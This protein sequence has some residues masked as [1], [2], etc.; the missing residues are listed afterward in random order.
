M[1]WLNEGDSILV[2][3]SST[4][5]YEIKKVGGVVSCSC[6]AWKVLGG[7]AY[8]RL[9]KHILK[10]VYP[11]C[12]ITQQNRISKDDPVLPWNGVPSIFKL[13]KNLNQL[14]TVID[15]NFD[16]EDTDEESKEKELTK[17]VP[18]VLL[19]HNWEP[20]IDPTGYWISEKFDGCRAWW[21]GQ[22]FISRLGN[23]FHAPEWFKNKFPK[24]I[25]LDGELWAGRGKFQETM[26][27]V[28]KLIPNDQEWANIQYVVFD[29]PKNKAKFEKRVSDLYLI[30]NITMVNQ[31][32]CS[33]IDHLKE[34]LKKVEEKGGEGLMLR[35]AGSYYE[36]GRS[37]TLLKVKTWYDAEATVIAHIP[38]KGKHKGRLGALLVKMPNDK[39]FELGTGFSDKERENPPNIGT[40][41][42]YRYVK[43][44][45]DGIPNPASY[46]RIAENQ[47]RKMKK[48][49]LDPDVFK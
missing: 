28:K 15:N 16:E 35:Q 7:P 34:E 40:V 11:D 39:E 8:S 20:S 43:L 36:E 17:P 41:I 1:K 31:N 2:K 14:K 19:A 5:P 45:K 23:I 4:K 22:N 48:N 12:M 9:C 49:I 29:M 13:N 46:W 21:D 30:P 26:S 6:I 24:D 27:I 42:T 44:T 10:N 32:I 18:P 25:I 3:G 47:P 38:G 37:S 33:G